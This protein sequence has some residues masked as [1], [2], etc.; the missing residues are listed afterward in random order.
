MLFIAVCFYKVG[1]SLGSGDVC[2]TNREVVAVETLVVVRD[3]GSPCV[4]TSAYVGAREVSVALQPE[5]PGIS[6]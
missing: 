6:D 3:D 1:C 2:A 4:T 5:E